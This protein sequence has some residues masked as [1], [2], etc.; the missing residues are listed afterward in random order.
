M[1]AAIPLMNRKVAHRLPKRRS[2]SLRLLHF[3]RDS[4]VPASCFVVLKYCT[5]KPSMDRLSLVILTREAVFVRNRR[6]VPLQHPPGIQRHARGAGGRDRLQRPGGGVPCRCG[7][8]A[9]APGA[10]RE[11]AL[12][13]GSVAGGVLGTQ[14]HAGCAIWLALWRKA[15]DSLCTVYCFALSV[16][17][18]GLSLEDTQRL[19]MPHDDAATMQTGLGQCLQPPLC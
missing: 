4:A 16:A 1:R 6:G 11:A 19:Q 3:N 18:A 7:D 15:S 2:V 10:G 9:N 17:H 5:T 12:A 13:G 14:G 8:A